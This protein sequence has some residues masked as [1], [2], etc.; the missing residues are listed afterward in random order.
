MSQPAVSP[1]AGS[2]ACEYKTVKGYNEKGFLTTATV[3]VGA[4]TTFD[5]R[6]FPVTVYPQGCEASA[7]ALQNKA[8]TQPTP[9]EGV[10]GAKAGF[11]TS[12][13][14]MA[15]PTDDSIYTQSK[16]KVSKHT[17]KSGASTVAARC[18]AAFG[19]FLS[20]LLFLA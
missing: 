10:I 20:A 9:S 8:L 17:D 18:C 12:T 13:T 2:S 1:A 7:L 4:K 11:A 3:P 5:D 14:A 15:L 19:I 16:K 6:G